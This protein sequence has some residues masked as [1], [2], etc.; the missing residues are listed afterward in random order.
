M[1]AH[2]VSEEFVAKRCLTPAVEWREEEEMRRNGK[3][4]GRAQATPR[5]EG[6]AP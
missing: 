6:G 4:L 3:S 2:I 5:A 1:F